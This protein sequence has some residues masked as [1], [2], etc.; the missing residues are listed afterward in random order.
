VG[1]LSEVTGPGFGPETV[2]VAACDLTRQHAGE[3]ELAGDVLQL[4]DALGLER[5]RFCGLSIGR[6][7]GFWLGARAPERVEG[8]TSS[9][10]PRTC[11]TWKRPSATTPS[12]AGSWA[13]KEPRG[14]IA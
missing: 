5:V 3:P 2:D 4:L 14:L 8:S 12:S 7:V 11:R 9:S 6:L 13:R 1:T 10:T